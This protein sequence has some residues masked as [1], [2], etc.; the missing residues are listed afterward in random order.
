MRWQRLLVLAAGFALGPAVA[1]SAPACP[2]VA[3][4]Q[5]GWAVARPQD[6]GLD[7]EAICALTDKL[8]ALKGA[9]AHGVVIARD[10]ALV[11]EAYFPGD[12]QRWPQQHWKEKLVMTGHDAE[13][14]HDVQSISKS[15]V[16]LLAGAALERNLLKSVDTSVLSLFPD[17]ADLHTAERDRI[18]VRDVLTM[19]SGLSW[20][21]RP[22]LGMSHR[23]E[24][25]ADPARFVLEQPMV[26][27]PGIV[28]RYNNGSAEVMGALLKKVAAKP[29]DRSP[30]RC[31]STR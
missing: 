15:V 29:I 28:W 17:Y 22:Y 10:G 9:N 30:R 27:E 24:A 25:A 11:Y 4:R 5:D 12:D 6:R 16:A 3:S 14:R 26:A 20:P 21:Q 7:A 19:T 2:G 23:M 8:T 18:R 31:C 1:W 13:T